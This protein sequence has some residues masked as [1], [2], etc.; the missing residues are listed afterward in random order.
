L[1]AFVRTL[2]QPWVVGGI[3]IVARRSWQALQFPRSCEVG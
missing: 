2:E 1:V 3:S